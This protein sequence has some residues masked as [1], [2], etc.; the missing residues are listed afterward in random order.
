MTFYHTGSHH[1]NRHLKE[2]PIDKGC[3]RVYT[4]N[5]RI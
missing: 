5:C 2:Y 1:V 4:S 3:R